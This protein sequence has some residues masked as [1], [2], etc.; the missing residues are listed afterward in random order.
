MWPFVTAYGLRAAAMNGNASVADAAYQSLMRG[1][2]LNISNME[3]LEWL[4]GQPVLLDEKN[5][6]LIGPV[7][8][9]R[10][11]L[12]SVG[13]YLGM[14]VENVFGISPSGAGIGISPFI[15]GKLRRETFGHSDSITLQRLRLRGKNIT[16]TIL[17]PPAQP[18][19]GYFAVDS[20]TLNGARMPG[21]IA[22]GDLPADSNIE[23]RLGA[24]VP[25]HQAI[26]RVSADPYSES[27]A[28]FGPREPAIASLARDG[29]GQVRLD[30]NG[31]KDA[32]GTVY[33][34][35]RDGKLAAAGVA[36]G[37]WTDRGAGAYACY[38]VEAQFAASGNRSH[39]SAASCV[40]TGIQV[41][42][43]DARVQSN[44]AV[45]G[46]VERFAAPHLKDWGKP[47]DS[48]AINGIKAP[49]AGRYQVQ[50]RYHNGANQINL[51]ISGGVKWLAVKDA[52]GR[53][54]ARGVVQLPHARIEKA[55]TPLVYST[56]LAVNL[57]AGEYKLEL[58]DFYNMSYLQ[59]N[60]TFSAAG[61]VDGASNRFDIYGV[62]LLRVK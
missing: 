48:F 21:T 6:S 10:R 51:G 31:G 13:A 8:N 59:S 53:I 34:V 41:P 40:D 18:G 46:P 52:S 39:H 28:V 30:I 12:W 38:S 4:S 5:P 3:N 37:A 56:P 19:D 47:S 29:A 2:A 11:Q 16:V 61:G 43:T 14:V 58:T 24:L 20:V 22:W 25:G 44:V 1:A 15:T 50:V 36:A 57:R 55:N 35:Y 42:V 60:S 33:N 26:H 7:I 23:I 45:S 54:V 32:A 49:A 9:S 62:R 17:L 27:S